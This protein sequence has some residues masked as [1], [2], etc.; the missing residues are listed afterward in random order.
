VVQNQ[1][2]KA[3]GMWER[4]KKT[5][6]FISFTDPKL[7]RSF[8]QKQY[9][10]NLANN[11]VLSSFGLVI[12]SG[13][14]LMNYII[15]PSGDVLRYALPY[16]M[17]FAGFSLIIAI[18]SIQLSRRVFKPLTMG[19][20]VMINVAPL[21]SVMAYDY[22]NTLYF[23]CGCVIL[24]TIGLIFTRISLYYLV[25][26]T[27]LFVLAFELMFFG[28]GHHSQ[29]ETFNLNF[30]LVVS[31]GVGLVVAYNMEKRERIN[32]VKLRI[33]IEERMKLSRLKDATPTAAPKTKK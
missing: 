15:M 12:Y 6:L 8:L 17:G 33:I 18:T 31:M 28:T 21:I 20:M 24:A 32:F 9:K 7:E 4:V 29:A 10:D 14:Y 23:H 1:S 25:G 16:L 22:P 30:F 11:R 2:N 27:A 19:A 5:I 13:Y 26:F 3:P